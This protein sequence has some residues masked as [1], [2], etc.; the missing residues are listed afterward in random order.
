MMS[1]HAQN[2]VPQ[3]EPISLASD[4]R[5]FDVE[6]ATAADIGRVKG[7]EFVEEN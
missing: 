1:N 4:S 7:C 2:K 6:S 5:F 3:D